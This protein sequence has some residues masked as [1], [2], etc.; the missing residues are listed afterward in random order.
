MLQNAVTNISISINN[1][2]ALKC[3]NTTEQN[4]NALTLSLLLKK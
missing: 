4:E 1:F 3:N 2:S